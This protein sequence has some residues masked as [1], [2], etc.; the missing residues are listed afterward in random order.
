MMLAGKSLAA[1]SGGATG[2]YS[3][4]T[5]HLAL[6]ET[7]ISSNDDDL[8]GIAYDGTTYICSTPTTS[9]RKSANLIAWTQ[10]TIPFTPGNATVSEGLSYYVNGV[11]FITGDNGGM[12]TSPDG[13]TWTDRSFAST[14]AV[15]RSAAYGNS[16]YVVITTNSIRTS[17]TLASWTTRLS[18]LNVRSLVWNGT[19]FL[20]LGGSGN[21]Y[22]STDGITWTNYTSGPSGV[23][24]LVWT[25]SQYIAAGSGG[26]IA[27]STD[28]IT[29]TART[30]GTSDDFQSLATNGSVTI[31]ATDSG[32][33]YS[34][35]D[36]ITWTSR[37][38][39]IV[40]RARQAIWDGSQF[41]V[42]GTHGTI[43][44][45][46]STG[47]TWSVYL[48]Q[49]HMT[50]FAYSS[51]L[52]RYAVCGDGEGTIQTSSNG[53][54]WSAT[55]PYSAGFPETPVGVAWGDASGYFV[56]ASSYGSGSVF[57][58]TNGTSWSDT[59]SPQSNPI[60]IGYANNLFVMVGSSGAL[61]TSSTYTSWTTRTT[62]TTANLI[63]VAW[64]GS[65]A[66]VVGT[67]G[68]IITSPDCVTWTAR[69]SGVTT[70]LRGVVWTGT[71]FVI[72]GDSGRVL[73]S[74][75]GITWTIRTSISGS[76]LLYGVG[77]DGT[78]LIAGSSTGTVYI[79]SDGGV[80]WQ[81]RTTVTTQE[82]YKIVTAGSRT[83]AVG[84]S[85][86]IMSSPV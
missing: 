30:S 74:P 1:T 70:T 75:D 73:T 60:G 51:S 15:T 68:T 77:W 82:I 11:F 80:S 72:V 47:T 79:S 50:G 18:G 6:Y 84:A 4:W 65:L 45:S 58:S 83:Y 81:S 42:V 39:P 8:G 23:D 25:G 28:G 38:R 71:Q 22:I 63:D 16:I 40:I 62:G 56:G 24:C 37:G 36:G 85:G 41:I 35:T 48:S 10:G 12:A 3:T 31:A 76:P 61:A 27:T 69:T 44:V 67:S 64:D 9:I 46:N 52:G 57:Y 34:S 29:W 32:R 54:S 55:T 26:A 5:R 13:I 14:T 21:L 43:L 78:W 49:V 20:V 19:Q 2:A 53:T 17:P 59:S 7:G 86:N 66:V 33:L